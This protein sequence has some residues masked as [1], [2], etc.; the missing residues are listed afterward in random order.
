[1]VRN[2]LAVLASWRSVDLSVSRG[3]LPAGERL[4]PA[5]AVALAAQPDLLRR[6]VLLLDWFFAR[7][8][9][10]VAPARLI[11]YEDTVR[12]GGAGLL[13]AAGVPATTAAPARLRSRNLNP[14]YAAAEVATLVTALREHATACWRSYP[15][16]QVQALAAAICRGSAADA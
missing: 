2:P 7:L 6:Q 10:W 3:C 14:Q 9:R 11:R 15:L 12:E 4:D 13:Q 16:E 8:Q 1:M 5:L